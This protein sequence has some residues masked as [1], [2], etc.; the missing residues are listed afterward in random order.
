MSKPK[1]DDGSG[2]TSGPPPDDSSDIDK[3]S[4]DEIA[5]IQLSDDPQ[6]LEANMERL[7]QSIDNSSARELA[8][9]QWTALKKLIAAGEINQEDAQD[10]FEA[11]KRLGF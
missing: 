10:N 8:E 4:P 5:A 11:I 7:F 1:Q 3:L 9:S 6:E 2:L